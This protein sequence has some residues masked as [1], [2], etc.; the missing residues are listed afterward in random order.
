MVVNHSP[1]VFCFRPDGCEPACPVGS[2]CARQNVL[3]C[4]E[5]VFLA[6][7]PHDDVFVAQSLRGLPVFPKTFAHSF[8]N[9]FDAARRTGR[10]HFGRFLRISRKILIKVA[11]VPTLGG[12]LEHRPNRLFVLAL[13]ESDR[14]AD[15]TNKNQKKYGFSHKSP[16]RKF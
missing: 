11:L 5:R 13:P 2:A 7:H 1:A 16:F 3:P 12:Y 4:N 8:L 15:G 14:R 9:R 6:E 10:K